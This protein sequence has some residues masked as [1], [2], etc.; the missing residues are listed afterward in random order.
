MHIS[1]LEKYRLAKNV[2]GKYVYYFG[3]SDTRTKS[4]VFRDMIS[5]S[6]TFHGLHGVV[7]QKTEL[8]LTIDVRTSNPTYT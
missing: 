1:A 3:D 4:S 7:S 6:L 2:P 5:C 8:L